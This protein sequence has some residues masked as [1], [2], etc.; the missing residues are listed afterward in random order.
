MKSELFK[1]EVERTSSV[2]GRKKD[3]RVIFTG[4]EAK[5]DGN[6][7][8][9]PSIDDGVMLTPDQM[10]MVRGYVDHEAG[11]VRHSDMDVSEKINI[12]AANTDNGF[13]RAMT[14]A[15]EDVRLE[16][17]VIDE[18]PGAAK[19]LKATTRAVNQ[20]FLEHAGKL[21]KEELAE[22]MAD[23]RLIGAGAVTWL[24]RL[25]YGGEECQ[26]LMDML[27][28]GVQERVAVWTECVQHC[29]STAACAKL[30][31]DIDAELSGGPKVE[32]PEGDY[33]STG[34]NEKLDLKKP[35]KKKGGDGDGERRPGKGDEE[36]IELNFGAR[37]LWDG[38]EV[39]RQILNDLPSA[40]K[41]GEGNY[42]TATTMFDKLHTRHDPQNRFLDE[43]G[44]ACAHWNPGYHTLGKGTIKGYQRIVDQIGPKVSVMR[45][46]LERAILAQQNRGWNPGLA[47]GRL[48]NRRLV[49]AYN[50]APNV[51]KQREDVPEMDSALSIVVDQSGSMSGEKAI[52]ATQC[53]IAMAE[54]VDKTGVSYEI[55]GFTER[56]GPSPSQVP[57]FAGTYNREVERSFR[58]WQRNLADMYTSGHYGN[59]TRI[60]PTDMYLYKGYD[61]S[62]REC[63][64]ALS[65]MTSLVGGGNID[66]ESVRQAYMRLAERREKRKMMVVFSD[67]HPSG[68]CLCGMALNQDLKRI[69]KDMINAGVHVYGIGIMDSSVSNFYPSYTVVNDL[70]DLAGVALDQLAKYLVGDRFAVSRSVVD[71]A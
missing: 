10:G 2:F 19:N 65:T 36:E 1:H 15:C 5:T 20:R 49:A 22:K 18:Y 46:R 38:S 40:P 58:E 50:R 54:A 9:M 14:N 41:G 34:W 43:S 59:W 8:I 27:P 37:D 63:R 28:A 51:F 56:L 17:L 21:S 68:G 57:E 33:S 30:A 67:G 3:L 48:D 25:H 42:T 12:H 55:V 7:V 24:G 64:G 11:H 39:Q 31:R 53:A 23:P 44:A 4:N 13:L 61:E 62:L 52:V 35:K 66:G 32:V 47:D 71:A 26:Q 70:D 45:R 69:V 6:V 29:R 16:A 60:N